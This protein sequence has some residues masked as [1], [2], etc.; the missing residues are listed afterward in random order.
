MTSSHWL[1]AVTLALL[2]GLGVIVWRTYGRRHKE[3]A[4]RPKYRMLDDD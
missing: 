3:D 1:L 4:E 2:V